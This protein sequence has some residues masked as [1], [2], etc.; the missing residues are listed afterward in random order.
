MKRRIK[1]ATRT[2]G[3]FVTRDYSYRSKQAAGDGWVT[4][5]DAFGFLDPLYSS[6]VLLALKA[7]AKGDWRSGAVLARLERL[8]GI[9]VDARPVLAHPRAAAPDAALSSLASE[10]L[11]R[12]ATV[13]AYDG[14]VTGVF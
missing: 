12:H 5:G 7:L 3:Y 14:G 1:D 4:I 2:T 9:A 8:A 6:G 11:G 13:Y 10:V